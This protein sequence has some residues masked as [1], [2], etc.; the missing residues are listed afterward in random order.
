MPPSG[1]S[2][3]A[4]LGYVTV[5]K[6]N[7]SDLFKEYTDGLHSTFRAGVE[8]ELKNL[9]TAQQGAALV[10]PDRGFVQTAIDDYELLL[11][12]LDEHGG[13]AMKAIDA[14]LAEIHQRAAALHV[15]G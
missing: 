10:G 7:F 12:K 1:H 13:D 9:R 11:A 6:S 8:Y 5:A 14:A 15:P 3:A 2:L 4:I